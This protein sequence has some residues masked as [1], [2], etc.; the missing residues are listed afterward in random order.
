MR[1]LDT[2]LS[3]L[4]PR[5]FLSFPSYSVLGL[6]SAYLEADEEMKGVFTFI[7]ELVN[8][9]GAHVSFVEKK[10]HLINDI[11]SKEPV[12]QCWFPLKISSEVLNPL[13]DAKER[14]L[15]ESLCHATLRKWHF[16]SICYSYEPE[17]RFE[18]LTGCLHRLSPKSPRWRKGHK[19]EKG[20]I[21]KYTVYFR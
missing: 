13:H 5:H 16:V 8:D 1:S 3:L 14:I 19:K 20:I 21:C 18:P 9:V 4:S 12:S 15:W 17:K 7:S 10:M 11:D 6:K 2:I